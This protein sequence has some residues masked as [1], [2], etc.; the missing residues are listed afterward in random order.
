MNTL[1]QAFGRICYAPLTLL[2]M[3]IY[4]ARCSFQAICGRFLGQKSCRHSS[5]LK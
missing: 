2:L 4:L 5:L 3:A 1:T